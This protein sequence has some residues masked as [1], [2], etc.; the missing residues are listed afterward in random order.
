MKFLSF[1][2]KSEARWMMIFG[3][4]PVAIASVIFLL[5]YLMRIL[6]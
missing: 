6:F 4:G 2:F 3:F 1:S 5:V